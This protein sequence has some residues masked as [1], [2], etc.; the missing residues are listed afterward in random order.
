MPAKRST[1]QHIDEYI[2]GFPDEVQETLSEIRRTIKEAVPGAAEAISYQI[3]AF[4][5]YGKPLIY[6]A[7]YRKHIAIYPA[8]RGSEAFK[9]EL[10]AYAGGKGTV[11][12]P[13]DLPIPY[14]LIRRITEFRAKG[15]VDE[16][17]ASS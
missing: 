16:S 11:Q 9:E 15:I 7:A 17:E 2:A 12:F 1:P 3:P 14:D 10:S 5:L 4:K 13:L 6:F 8:P